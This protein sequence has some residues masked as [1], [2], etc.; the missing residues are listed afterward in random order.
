MHHIQWHYGRDKKVFHF[1]WNCPYKFLS[2]GKMTLNFEV[3]LCMILFPSPGI[4]ALVVPKNSTVSN[5][6]EKHIQSNVSTVLLP[7]LYLM[8]FLVGLPSNLLALGVLLFRTKR[9]PSTTLLINLTTCDLLLLVVLPFRIAYHFNGNNWTLG[10]PLCRLVMA[11]FYGN[12]Y[13]SVLYLA[14]I[15]FDRYLALVH[16]IGGRMIRSYRNSVYMSVAA[17]AV[18][19][20]AMAPLLAKQHTYPINFKDGL[21]ITTCHDTLP[22]DIQTSFFVPYFA[23]LFATCFVIPLL[24]VLFCY[25][26]ILHALAS[27][28]RRYGH[29]VR[30]TVLVMTVFIVCLLPS[31]VLLFIHNS[32]MML[33]DEENSLYIPY[34]LTLALSTFNNCLDPFIFYFVSEDFREK[35]QQVLFCRDYKQAKTSSQETR[36]S[37]RSKVT[38]LSATGRVSAT[39]EAASRQGGAV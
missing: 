6:A 17:W 20:I 7:L 10:E 8:A 36:S 24:V 31:N 9:Q 29:A 25:G 13:G 21:N 27:S 37:E 23:T 4:R 35:A 34:M 14:L 15:A 30:V 2:L 32:S 33:K 22:I 1:R 39:T 26:S 3:T 5:L 11:L 12:M 18:V 16:P 19:L 28:G 38:L